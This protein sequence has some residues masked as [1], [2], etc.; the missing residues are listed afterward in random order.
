MEKFD[1]NLNSLEYDFKKIDEINE[2]LFKAK[3]SLEKN[4]LNPDTIKKYIKD[5]KFYNKQLKK[6]TQ[7]VIQKCI[8]IYW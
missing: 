7:K 4:I 3:D 8:K 2:Q 6:Y 5:F 1:K